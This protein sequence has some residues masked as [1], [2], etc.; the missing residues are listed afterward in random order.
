MA[1]VSKDSTDGFSTYTP[2]KPGTTARDRRYDIESNGLKYGV[3]YPVAM[4]TRSASIRPRDVITCTP[5][6]V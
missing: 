5:R 4:M 2:Y 3:A 1:W 6:R